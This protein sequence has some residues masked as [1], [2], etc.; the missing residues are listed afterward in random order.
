MEPGSESRGASRGY[1][2]G[3]VRSWEKVEEVGGGGRKWEEW[4]FRPDAVCVT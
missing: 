1:G 2:Q 3:R 4:G